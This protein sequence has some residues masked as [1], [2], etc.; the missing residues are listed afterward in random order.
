MQIITKSINDI[1]PYANNPRNNGGAVEA[2]AKS[3]KEF[4]F[5]VP[6]VISQD[7]EIITGHTRHKA[8]KLLGLKKVPC[9]IADDLS[10]EQIKAFRLVD[11][12]VGELAQWDMPALQIELDELDINLGGFGFPEKNDN[13]FVDSLADSEEYNSFVEKFEPKK[14]TDDCYTP[15]EVY[16][17]IKNWAVEKYGLEGREIIRPFKPRG[18]YQKENYPDGCIVLDNPPFSILSEIVKWYTAQGVDYFLFAPTLTLFSSASGTANYIYCN[19]S[20]IYQNGARVNTSFVTNLGENK[21]ETAYRLNY[22]LKE[23]QKNTKELP[24]LVYLK[25]VVTSNS[26]GRYANPS[27]EIKIKNG[28]YLRKLENQDGRIYGSGFLISHKA[29]AEIEKAEIERER[30]RERERAIVYEL[31]EKEKEIIKKLDE[32]EE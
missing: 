25:N 14:T 5:K 7:G 19:Q 12:K 16:E 32:A 20:I 23:I 3:I 22:K 9:I 10:E 27:F 29:Q 30:A 28:H 31:S 4:G 13:F 18:D 6:L 24:K 11:N 26:L 17:C 1:K 8:A 21:I 2:V 15:P